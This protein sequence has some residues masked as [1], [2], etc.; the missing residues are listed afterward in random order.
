MSEQK[1]KR[2]LFEVNTATTAT[3]PKT[4]E[5]KPTES[6]DDIIARSKSRLAARMAP[7]KAEPK[8]EPKEEPKEEPKPVTKPPAPPIGRVVQSPKITTPTAPTKTAQT[9]SA[10]QEKEKQKGISRIIRGGGRWAF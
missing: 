7:P 6:I 2:N 9:K 8:T 3:I 1:N 5:Q 4:V 10:P